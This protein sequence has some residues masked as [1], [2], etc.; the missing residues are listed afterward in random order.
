M[1]QTTTTKKLFALPR[2][3]WPGEVGLRLRAARWV[4]VLAV[5]AGMVCAFCVLTFVGGLMALDAGGIERWMVLVMTGAAAMAVPSGYAALVGLAVVVLRGRAAV[6]DKGRLMLDASGTCYAFERGAVRS[7]AVVRRERGRGTVDVDL[8][9]GPHRM[10]SR[11]A[12]AL[13]EME[14]AEGRIRFF[15][16]FDPGDLRRFG[17]EVARMAGATFREYAESADTA[18]AAVNG[19][20]S[21]GKER[22]W[23]VWG[24]VILGLLFTALASWFVVR[25]LQ[26]ERWPTTLGRVTDAVY[27]ERKNGNAVAQIRYEYRVEARD[28]SN[29]RFGFG[30]GAGDGSVRRLLRDHPHGSVIRVH[31]NPNS[32]GDSVVMAGVDWCG[33]LLVGVG[34]LSIV[35][36]L[37][38]WIAGP[39]WDLDAIVRP[40]KIPAGAEAEPE[41]EIVRWETPG[42]V[43]RA[44]AQ[45]RKRGDLWTA[46]RLGVVLVVILV[47]YRF[48]AKRAVPEWS[49]GRLEWLVS[50]GAA[51]LVG[52]HAWSA[53]LPSAG[54]WRARAY[55]LTERGIGCSG[56]PIVIAWKGLSEFRVDVVPGALSH[57]RVMLLEKRGRVTGIVALPGDER[58][59]VILEEFGKRLREDLTVR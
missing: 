4:K 35:C 11:R 37:P 46:V 17:A 53:L 33:W 58:D 32:P 30:K 6:D 36:V 18:A 45:R 49:W 40:Y 21:Y 47:A 22:V 26:S 48:A 20:Y 44:E 23:L 1:E 5:L 43:V 12:A 57:R 14:V 19:T 29:D 2:G 27:E 10:F 52:A 7:V 16:D 8:T 39:R 9:Q 54:N 42:E 13:L 3:V 59:L 41:V 25:G 31:Y 38:L 34:M 56:Q 24:G 28:Y 50:G 51:L 55:W 15:R